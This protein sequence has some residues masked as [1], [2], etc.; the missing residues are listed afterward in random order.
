MTSHSYLNG[1]PEL[2]F[3]IFF[4]LTRTIF[5][6]CTHCFIYFWLQ[7]VFVAA[8]GLSLVGESGGYFP[9]AVY[10]LLITL[11]LLLLSHFSRVRL[12]ATP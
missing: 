8:H 12:C 5:L 4:F 9:V 1:C 2:L 10:K 11:L 7:R 3:K 6:T